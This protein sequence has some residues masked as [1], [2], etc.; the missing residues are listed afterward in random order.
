MLQQPQII[1]KNGKAEFVVIPFQ[2]YLDMKE[3]LE[4]FNDLKE[5]RKAKEEEK[6]VKSIPLN[7]VKRELNI[8]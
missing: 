4:D 3:M 7:S 1:T 5:L 8:S 6:N 2:D